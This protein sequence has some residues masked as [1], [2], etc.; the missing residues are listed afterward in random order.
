M[1]TLERAKAGDQRAR[2]DIVMYVWEKYG[3]KIA[4]LYSPDPAD[5]REDLHQIFLMGVT[6]ALAKVD[7]RGNPIWHLAVR[8]N[9][10]VSRHIRTAKEKARERSLDYE[11]FEGEGETAVAQL[12]DESVDVEG[13]V[14]SQIGTGQQVSLIMGANLSPTARRAME[15]I[16]NDEAGDPVELGFN[17]RLADALEV[18]PQRASQAMESLRK[19]VDKAGIDT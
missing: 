15:A 8:G 18:S 4:Y 2:E 10:A 3:G 19:G 11:A 1:A 13:L 5:E 9:W 6:D 16:L 17:K 14:L 7:H 12:R